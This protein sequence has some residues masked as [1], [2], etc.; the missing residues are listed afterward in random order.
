MG[1]STG[2]LRLNGDRRFGGSLRF[3]FR[4]I[5]VLLAF[6]PLLFVAAFLGQRAYTNL[7]NQSLALQQEVAVGVG[8]QL[9]SAILGREAELAHLDGVFGLGLASESRQRVVLRNLISHQRMY[10]ELALLNGDGE[11]MIRV[12]RDGVV[13]NS[14]L[15]SRADDEAYVHA[16]RDKTTH[17]GPVLYDAAAR[18]PLTTLAYPILDRRTGSIDSVV[19]ATVSFKPI[20]DLLA[21][22]ELPDGREV[23]LVSS[24]GRVVAHP[25][26][27]VVLRGT[28]YTPP[29]SD[30]RAAGFS[31]EEAIVAT[32][33]VALGEEELVVVAE[34]PLSIALRPATQALRVTIVVTVITLLAVFVLIALVTRRLVR[35]IEEL[36]ASARKVA[37]GDL[38]HRVSVKNTDEIGALAADFNYMTTRLQNIIETLEKRVTERTADLEAASALQQTL[39]AELESNNAEM[40]R[41]HEKLEELM[42]SKDEFLGSV[43]HEL[44]TPLSSVLG[45]SAELRDRYGD[46]DE[47]ERQEL[48]ELITVQGQDMA[49]IINDLLVAARA[50][51]TG[52]VVE[53]SPIDVA[54]DIQAV[55]EHL[56]EVVIHVDLP[57]RPAEALGDPVRVRQ[58]MRNLIV[59]ARRYGGPNVEVGVC[60]KN[61]FVTIQVRDNGERIPEDEWESIFDPYQR[62]HHQKGQPASVGL[63]LTVSRMLA[64]RMDGD[65]TYRYED[66]QSVFELVLPTADRH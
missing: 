42:R 49:N 55:L 59:N 26:P 1:D 54:A 11:E 31:G 34:Q 24:A 18:E 66:N 30:G 7:E 45:F 53:L 12:A 5:V 37:D 13:L 56:P 4:V 32:F 47:E 38:A 41:V 2:G 64:R 61:G 65:L 19:V 22:L 29:E 25:N 3:R 44:R 63:G 15:R 16:V 51:L 36:A 33:N 48:M 8:N 23:F 46:F 28:L 21:G 9:R 39:I 58:I 10:R 50:D 57:A 40:V 43:S 20:W 52:L 17:F 60:G 62:S 35:P 27:A 6:V 14:E